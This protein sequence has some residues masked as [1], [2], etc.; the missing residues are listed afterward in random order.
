MF[1]MTLKF[2]LSLFVHQCMYFFFPETMEEVIFEA[3]LVAHSPCLQF[4][5][6]L[7][8]F[9]SSVSKLN[10]FNFSYLILVLQ[11]VELIGLRSGLEW[12]NE[13]S[14]Y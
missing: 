11:S 10:W 4:M 12:W 3:S 2:D 6:T 9:L 13:I 5:H 8:F 14:W 7:V 1:M